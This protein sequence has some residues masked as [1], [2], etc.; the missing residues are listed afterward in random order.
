[1]IW[2]PINN[3]IYFVD[4]NGKFGYLGLP[5]GST[6]WS[7]NFLYVFSPCSLRMSVSSNFTYMAISSS[8]T[9][10]ILIYNI[11]TNAYWANPMIPGLNTVAHE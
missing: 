11:I 7:T 6:T 8:T 10:S 3:N 5:P 1:M 2:S 9:E 4:L